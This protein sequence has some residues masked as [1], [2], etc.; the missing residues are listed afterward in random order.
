[1]PDRDPFR[2]TFQRDL[3]NEVIINGGAHPE[4]VHTLQRWASLGLT[5]LCWRNSILED[6]HAGPDSRISDGGMLMSN[7]ATTRTYDW[8]LVDLFRDWEIP[9]HACLLDIADI[10]ADSLAY[11]L[12][13]AA[14][15]TTD[16][17]RTLPTGQTLSDLGGTQV[18]ELNKHAR[19]QAGALADISADSGT[20]VV[21]LWLAARGLH[22]CTNWWGAPTWP[23]HVDR[24]LNLINDPTHPHWNNTRHPGTPPHPADDPE[25]FRYTLLTAPDDLTLEVADWCTQRAGIGYI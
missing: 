3:L 2:D 22:T 12:L 15:D 11:H 5:S 20:D 18:D 7:V 19:T 13:T 6:W 21:F 16:P 17:D 10:E 1:M 23:A 9:R 25:W 4:D 8:A 24:F 14:D